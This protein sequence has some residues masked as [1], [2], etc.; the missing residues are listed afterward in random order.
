M[1]QAIQEATARI[2]RLMGYTGG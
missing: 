1:G 2:S